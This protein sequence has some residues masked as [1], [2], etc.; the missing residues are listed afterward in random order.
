MDQ[1]P[2]GGLSASITYAE[3]KAHFDQHQG[4]E[5]DPQQRLNRL[6]GLKKYQDFCGRADTDPIGPEFNGQFEQR[7]VAFL[8]RRV[9]PG[10][11]IRFP[12][13]TCTHSWPAPFPAHVEQTLKKRHIP[14]SPAGSYFLC[15]LS[16]SSRWN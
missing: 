9:L 11:T 15:I 16:R 8:P 14:P 13:E 2:E 6:S 1:N 3:L 5:I 4:A 12:G 7:R 10:R